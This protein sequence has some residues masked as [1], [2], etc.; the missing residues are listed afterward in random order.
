MP[1][2]MKQLFD[3]ALASLNDEPFIWDQLDNL[4]VRRTKLK[5]RDGWKDELVALAEDKG[6][7]FYKDQLIQVVNEV[8]E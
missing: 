3:C 6:L 8:P 2:E 5:A 4:F 1:H 7:E